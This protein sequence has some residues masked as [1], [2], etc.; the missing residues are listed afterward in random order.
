VKKHTPGPWSLSTCGDFIVDKTG[1]SIARI[2]WAGHSE[3]AEHNARLIAA[4][5][6][7]LS[8]VKK[9]AYNEGMIGEEDFR[10]AMWPI[11]MAAI[12]KTEGE[13]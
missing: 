2:F 7:L 4:A 9:L 13:D 8:I 10:R 5:P 1:G 3:E 12:A 11:M 6:E